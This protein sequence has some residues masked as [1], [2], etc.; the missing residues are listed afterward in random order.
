MSEPFLTGLDVLAGRKRKL[1]R[2]LKV[3]L[4]SHQPA[5]CR[6]GEG[7]AEMLRSTLGAGLSAL[8]GPEHGF[9]G[10]ENAV[11]K[12][13]SA[14]HPLWKI[15]VYSLY[16]A[17]R[18]P[19][20]KMLA[21]LEL[22]VIALRDIAARPYTYVSTLRLALESAARLEL[23]VIVADMS[24]PPLP[25]AVD[26]PMPELGYESF[27]CLVPAPMA[28]GMT[29]AETALWLKKKLRLKLDLK[30]AP[31]RGWS[32][33]ADPRRG[34]TPWIPPSPGI[35][36]W[37]SGACYL[38]TVFAEALPA[39]DY[40]KGAGIPFQVAGAPGLDA[41]LVKRELDAL[42]LPGAVFHPHFY[43][44]TSGAKCAGVRISVSNPAVFRPV[45]TGVAVL[46]ALQR[47]MGFDAL[48]NRP[49]AR[50]EFFDKLYGSPAVRSALAC[51]L[52]PSE[53]A[54]GWRAQ[55]EDFRRERAECL[56]Y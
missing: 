7:A 24:P 21:G 41:A 30:L 25:R 20:G 39:I 8:L 10:T 42:D 47:V 36:S 31:M 29:Q 35:R 22:L 16:G 56:L 3:G 33:R 53:I 12:T 9:F 49:G 15:P 1:L 13:K 34:L 38:S 6:H 19:T 40:G 52:H 4:L 14:R 18:A 27:V 45:L 5:V 23:P 46:W 44:D 50:P 54:A 26:G 48:W 32:R 11:E 2:G 37:E 51:G 43:L 55:N 17:T 28:Y